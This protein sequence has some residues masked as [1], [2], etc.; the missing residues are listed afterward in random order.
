MESEGLSPG[1]MLEGRVFNKGMTRSANVWFNRR[2]K[3]FA[4]HR[5]EDRKGEGFCPNS[6]RR[7]RR[8]GK[9][10][11]VNFHH[12]REMGIVFSSSNEGRGTGFNPAE[13][14]GG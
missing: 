11:R 9:V 6:D 7:R 13:E 3:V 14:G 5:A 8:V 1:M 10:F 2:G 12:R 4:F